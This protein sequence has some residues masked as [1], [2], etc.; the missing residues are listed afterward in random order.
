MSLDSDATI[1]QVSSFPDLPCLVSRVVTIY[2]EQHMD[3]LFL[4][5]SSPVAIPRTYW[6]DQSFSSRIVLI[7]TSEREWYHVEQ[8]MNRN[9]SGFDMDILND[10]YKESCIVV[11]HRR[12][13]LL[14]GKFR[15]DSHHKYLGSDEAL[16]GARA[17]DE[18]KFVHLSDWSVP[19][20]RLETVSEG[21][22]K[23]QPKC[24]DGR[25]G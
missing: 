12:Y 6:L 13:D 16:N 20:T 14:T 25:R 8:F 3:E 19:K 11:P 15:A 17:I 23:H 22:E 21:I 2:H 1:K 9:D 5:P 18:A 10:M 7:E 24:R 4:I